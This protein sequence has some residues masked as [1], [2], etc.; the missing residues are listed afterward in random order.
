[1]PEVMLDVHHDLA[2]RAGLHEPALGAEDE[3]FFDG[4][5]VS[6]GE[7]P[8]WRL[9]KT[10]TFS[11]A[12]P[13]RVLLARQPVES[14][15]SD[16]STLQVSIWHSVDKPDARLRVE[17]IET[18][19]S[20]EARQALIRLAGEIECPLLT[21]WENRPAGEV[22]LSTPNDALAMFTRGNHVHVI[23]SA[24]REPVE[25]KTAA[26]TLDGWLKSAGTPVGEHSLAD[27]A[28]LPRSRP[29]AGTWTRFHLSGVRAQRMHRGVA[30]WPCAGRAKIVQFAVTPGVAAWKPM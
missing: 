26:T 6:G 24:G 20:A 16:L 11:V 7:L 23:R 27:P 8:G 25:V 19:S 1:M 21:R 15:V 10:T 22:A 18:A 30:L 13:P 2:M 29:D 3:Y 28:Q 5:S 9:A 12:A 14:Q 17:S 4:F